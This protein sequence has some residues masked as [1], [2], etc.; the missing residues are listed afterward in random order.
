MEVGTELGPTKT[1]VPVAST[2]VNDTISWLP[3]GPLLRWGAWWKTRGEE[4]RKVD[5]WGQ[6]SQ[7][8]LGAAAGGEE[9]TRPWKPPAW[10]LRGQSDGRVRMTRC[11]PR[12]PPGSWMVGQQA[13]RS[14]A[15]PTRDPGP[16]PSNN[17]R[18][19][20]GCWWGKGGEG[21]EEGGFASLAQGVMGKQRAKRGWPAKA[22]I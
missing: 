6:P 22:R 9:I 1:D 10:G 4:G 8:E 12:L 11:Q 5:H 16:D 14:H 3:G 17:S 13:D 20:L 19:I 15:Q 7:Q 18:I 2:G 21:R